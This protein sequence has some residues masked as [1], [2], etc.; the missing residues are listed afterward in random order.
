[1]SIAVPIDEAL[2]DPNLLGAALGDVETW[3]TWRAVLRAAFGLSLNRDDARAFAAVAGSRKPPEQRVRELWAVLGRRSGKS[4]M[5]AALAV[6]YAVLVDHTGRLAPGEVGYVLVLAASTAQARGIRDYAE[7]F[8][9]ASPLLA[10]QIDNTTSD[11]IRLRNGVVIGVHAANYRTVRG[12]TLLACIFDETAFW[13]SEESAQP[14]L[15]IYRAVI[16]ALATTGGMLVAIS[17]P[18]RRIGLLHTKHRDY[19][20][21]DDDAVLVIQGESRTFNPTLSEDL[22][23]RA[24]TEDPESALAEWDGQ[25]RSDLS[26]FLDDETIDAAIDETRPLELPPRDGIAYRAFVDAS[27]GRHDA[28]TIGIAHRE[29]ERY[30]VDVVRGRHPPFNPSDVAAEFAAL[31]KDYRCREVTGDNFSGEW[32]VTAFKAAGVNYKRAEKP[33]SVIY[34]EGLPIFARGAVSIPNVPRLVRELRLLERRTSRIGRD[35]IDHGTGGSDDFA[36][37]VFGALHI[38]TEQRKIPTAAMGHYSTAW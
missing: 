6:F 36:N 25:F 30:V 28:F 23:R 8:L 29:D 17:S 26:Q 9:Q 24:K 20:G 10:A 5:A 15:E 13:R 2:S 3:Q 32:V 7:G 22:I 1:V 12:R 14:D 34:L 19:F 35:I 27:A 11:E 16:P 33:K 21:V 31:A 37:S 4:R 18:Y 38:L